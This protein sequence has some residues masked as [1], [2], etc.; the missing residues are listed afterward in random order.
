MKKIYLILA[1]AVGMTITSCTTNDYLGE[2]DP[3]AQAV[4][5]DGSI[6]F[7]I[8]TK[9]MTRADLVGDA[10]AKKLGGM[11]VVEGTKGTEDTNKPSDDVVFDNYLVGFE[12]NSADKTA[13]NTNNWE[14]VGKQ[15]GITGRMT[16]DTWTALHPDKDA[17]DN[18]PA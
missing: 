5:N 1:A 3:N 4:V 12:Y 11:F 17:D 13:S 8:A 9:G 10:A 6:Q 16:G 14:Y 2:V 7:G 15:T 18:P